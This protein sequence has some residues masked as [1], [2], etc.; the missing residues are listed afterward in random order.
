MKRFHSVS[1]KITLA[2]ATMGLL[3]ALSIGIGLVVFQ[4]VSG[5]V[6]SVNDDRIPEIGA[7]TQLIIAAS[8]LNESLNDIARARSGADVRAAESVVTTRSQDALAA[9][10]TL[11]PATRDEIRTM[12]ADAEINLKALIEAR[13]SEFENRALTLSNVQQ[14]TSLKAAISTTLAALIDD[15]YFELV[16]GGETAGETVSGVLTNLLENDIRKLRLA[17]QIRAEANLL[18][19][20]LVS[21]SQTRDPALVSILRDLADGANRRYADDLAELEPFIE[22]PEATATLKQAGEYFANSTQTRSPSSARISEAL[23]S[24]QSVDSVLSTLLDDFEFNLTIEAE[25]AKETNESTIQDLLDVQVSQI[26]S[27]ATLEKAVRSFVA[28]GLEGA[29]AQD[30][31]A[32]IILQEKLTAAANEVEQ[33]LLADLGETE[34][35]IRQLL[36]FGNSETGVI[37]VRSHV[38]DAE[39]DAADLSA[40]ASAIVSSINATAARAGETALDRI[41]QSGHD[42]DDVANQAWSAMITVAIVGLAI[43]AGTRVFVTRSVA[44]P[45]KLLCSKTELLSAG[46][47]EPIGSLTR[48]KGEIGQMA[49]ALEV[50]RSNALKME[51]LREESARQEEQAQQRQKEMIALLSREIGGVVESGSRGD[52]SKRV[53]H[54]FEDPELATLADGVNQLVSSVEAGVTETQKSLTAIADADLTYRMDDRFEG[55]FA[56]LGEQTNATAKRLAQMVSEIR[57]AADVSTLRSSQVSEGAILLARQAENQAA[58]VQETSASMQSMTETVKSSA[59]TLVEAENLSRMVADKT[60]VGSEAAA[61][62]V[63]SVELIASHSEKITQINTVIETISFQTNLLALNAAVEAARAGD[64]GKGFAVVASEVRALAQKSADAATEINALVQESSKSVRFGVESVMDTRKVLEEIEAAMGPVMQA[65]EEVAQNGS[66]QA[67]SITDIGAAIGDIDNLTQ[68]NADLA[69]KSSSHAAEL[70]A[71]IRA[72]TELVSVFRVDDS[73]SSID[74]DESGGSDEHVSAA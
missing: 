19:G 25:T 12:I 21:L 32:M 34:A 44:R 70:M 61:R 2:I 42:L 66:S 50:F 57:S 10:E 36:A 65:I 18:S 72:L 45:L 59:N 40:D 47:M 55:I 22:D 69:E 74:G 4:A 9:T 38:L 56:E 13:S 16:V 33:N 6:R 7:S 67:T 39:Q 60:T 73:K 68:M 17:Q 26:L 54:E 3:T 11:D 51:E 46:N 43:F 1:L 8:G 35:N 23:A 29:F 24:R 28:L 64:A 15:S 31:P 63:Q 14:M 41:V 62:A 58:S 52:F 71:Q 5:Q 48:Q 30:E 27:I 53:L 49:N 37:A 20:L